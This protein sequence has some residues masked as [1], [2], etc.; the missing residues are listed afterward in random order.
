MELRTDRYK[1]KDIIY[2]NKEKGLIA[3]K[4]LKTTAASKFVESAHKISQKYHKRYEDIEFIRKGITI[5][6]EDIEIS[7]GE[8]A[9]V[10]LITTPRLDRDN[11]ILIPSGAILE[12]FQD[13]P[14]SLYAHD[15]TGL[16][17]GSDRWIKKVKEGLLAKTFYARHQF[18]D[19]VYNC[20]KD[21]HL[22][23]S[24]V[25][26]IPLESAT[27]EDREKFE[28]LQELLL[29]DYAVSKD[30]SGKAKNI[31]SSWILLE[32]S[33]V[34]VPSNQYALNLAVGK[35]LLKI[36][37]KR[38]IKDLEIEVI[39]DDREIEIE[40]DEK[41]YEFTEE[42]KAEIEF[43]VKAGKEVIKKLREDKE[44][45]VEIETKPETT[46]NYIRIPVSEGHDGHRIRTITISEDQGIKAIYCGTCKEI[47]TY[48][49]DRSCAE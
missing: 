1:L 34:P 24:S 6:P 37:S 42:E 40:K 11:E 28:Q 25:G 43:R 9:A 10:R 17:I 49:F 26:F 36:Q 33:D 3:L 27:P 14:V 38:L 4:E 15:Y 46:E 21:K 29:K 12:D 48:L 23:A 18:A 22:R 41:P 8:R 7:E 5:D 19:D 45:E 2:G 31:Y 16:P 39:K 35:N 30:E 44:V 47:M 32:H 13:N 20:V